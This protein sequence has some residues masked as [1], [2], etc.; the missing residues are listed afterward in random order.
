MN[1]LKLYSSDSQKVNIT[2]TV[3]KKREFKGIIKNS[4]ILLVHVALQYLT[5]QYLLCL[6]TNHV[7]VMLH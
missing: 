4:L 1:S 3:Y 6:P 2:V 5:L 7:Y